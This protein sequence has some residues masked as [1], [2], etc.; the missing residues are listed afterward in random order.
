MGVTAMILT[1]EVRSDSRPP[2]TH[3]ITPTPHTH[4]A[5]AFRTAI[6]T[7][8]AVK[9]AT[10]RLLSFAY[11]CMELQRVVQ[12]SHDLREQFRKNE[13]LYLVSKN[14]LT[15]IAA[16]NAGYE[17]K[18]DDLLS[19]QIGIAYVLD[20]PTAPARVIRNFEKENKDATLDVVGL[21]FEGELFSPDKYKELANLPSRDELLTKFV[22]SINQPMTKLVGTL[23]GVMTKFTMTLSSLKDSK[24]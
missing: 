9:V 7:M 19:G 23:N 24:S 15:K 22:G 5:S 10:V 12:N 16:K 18:L 13:V 14:T 8:F 2:T 11:H 6:A 20:D 3:A 1:A 17:D 21:V 4:V